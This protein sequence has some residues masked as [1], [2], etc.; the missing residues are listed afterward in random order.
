MWPARSGGAIDGWAEGYVD[1]VAT[2]A[3]ADGV[4][5]DGTD[6]CPQAEPIVATK[7]THPKRLRLACTGSPA[8]SELLHDPTTV[9][10]AGASST[11][12]A[13]GL[14]CSELSAFP[15]SVEMASDKLDPD[16]AISDREVFN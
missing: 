15:E 13:P 11:A 1:A 10:S 9:T 14:T 8:K 4:D 3:V 7:S 2:S 16:Y 5:P 12:I 6:P